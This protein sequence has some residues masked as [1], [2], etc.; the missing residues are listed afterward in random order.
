M[1]TLAA[2][3]LLA[4]GVSNAVWPYRMAR[5]GER[6]DALGTERGS[7]EVEPTDW[8]VVFTRLSGGVFL[9]GGVALALGA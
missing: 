8:N 6:L 5:L 1:P 2:A 9:F 4:F 7:G 3:L